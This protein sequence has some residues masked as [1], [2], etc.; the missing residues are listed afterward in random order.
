MACPD[1]AAGK[2]C[3]RIGTSGHSRRYGTSRAS[4]AR[5]AWANRKNNRPKQVWVQGED[6]L[7]PVKV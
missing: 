1:C 5:V 3:M 6:G 4:Q 7:R 2:G